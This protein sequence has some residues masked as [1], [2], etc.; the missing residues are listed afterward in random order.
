MRISKLS[1][2]ALIL[3]LGVVPTGGPCLAEDGEDQPLREVRTSEQETGQP[4]APEESGSEA[5]V[6]EE[7]TPPEDDKGDEPKEGGNDN[8]GGGFF[9]GTMLLPLL[10]LGAFV[11]MYLIMGRSRRK[12]E[13]KRREMLSTLKKGDKVVTIGG[14]VGTIIEVRDDE[15][16]VKV[17]ET[18]NTRMRFARWAVRG[19]G[20]EAKGESR[21]GR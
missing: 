7:G 17:D 9:G 14:I 13:A 16:T 4:P 15:L 1:I 11:L 8:G 21:Q 10:L 3:S 19:L 12:Q 6:K 5:P 20:E 18:N 2:A